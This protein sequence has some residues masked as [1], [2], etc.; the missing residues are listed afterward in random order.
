M[1]GGVRSERARHCELAGC[2]LVVEVLC[3]ACRSHLVLAQQSAMLLFCSAYF[4]LTV[5]HLA[6]F[7]AFL[8]LIYRIISYL[9]HFLRK[10]HV[11]FSACGKIYTP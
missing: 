11:L 1:C 7:F 5:V 2:A 6:V 3:H 8:I 9:N 10:T 4:E